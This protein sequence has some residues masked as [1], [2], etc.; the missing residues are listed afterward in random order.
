MNWRLGPT[1]FFVVLGILI[2]VVFLIVDAASSQPGP[3]TERELELQGQ[4]ER[5]RRYSRRLERVVHRQV[6]RAERNERRLI[7]KKSEL[8][9]VANTRPSVHRIISVAASAY[10][11]SYRL[12][13]NKAE[14]ESGLWPYARNP[15]SG[16]S[17]L[18]QFLP[19]T[20]RTTPLA[21]QSIYDPFANALAAAWMHR[22]G[23]GGEW[24]C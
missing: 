3:P 22:V 6:N 4:L 17:G 23:R 13:V 19:S 20:W 1:L 8:V 21:H 12:L 9:R 5:A 11:Q 18:F 10:G 15:S 14:C 2:A 7:R 24:V 16:A